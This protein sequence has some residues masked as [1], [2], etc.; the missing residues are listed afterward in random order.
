MSNAEDSFYFTE[1]YIYLFGLAMS[2]VV[3]RICNLIVF[4]KA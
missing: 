1:D 3:P 2:L 4:A